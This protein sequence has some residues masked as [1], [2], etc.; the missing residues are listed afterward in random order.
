M[1]K[2]KNREVEKNPDDYEESKAKSMT[3]YDVLR[4]PTN[5]TLTDIKKQFRK[6]AVMYHPDNHD[7][8]D[9]SI[10]ALVARAYECLSDDKKRE[11]YDRMLDIEKKVR[12]QNYI[13]QKKAFEEF[14]K[15]QDNDD[16]RTT[17]SIEA[18][19]AKYKLE[20]LDMDRKRGLDRSKL[21]EKPMTS[22]DARK[23]LNDMQMEREQDEI[24]C[25]QQ[26]IFSVSN[27]DRD[28]FNALFELKYK[29]ED[30]V[31]NQLVKHNGMPLAFNAVQQEAGPSFVSCEGN[32]KYDDIFDDNEN[33]SGNNL[34]GSVN[35]IGK[36]VHVSKDDL[37]KVKGIKKTD[38]SSHNVIS[39]D[40]ANDMEKKLREREMEDKLYE[41]RKM[42]DFDTDDKMGGYG[43]LHEVNLTGRELEWNKE[44]IDETTIKKLLMCRDLEDKEIKTKMN[45]HTQLPSVMRVKR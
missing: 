3:Y 8:G 22:T 14:I 32:D 37:D 33:V 39:K 1:S 16:S 13:N 19:T 11:E 25:S 7:T 2:R 30:K 6:A 45:S 40:Y 5:A 28:K 34:Y 27:F 17:K 43:F 23:R 12:K 10:F 24:E 4:V 26:E 21:D 44:D 38:Y 35:E 15:A 42:N 9:A 18:G 36:K 29:Q 20:F 31:D 41:A